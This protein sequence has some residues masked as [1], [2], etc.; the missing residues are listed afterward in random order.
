MSTTKKNI[1]LVVGLAFGLVIV[2]PIMIG[3]LGEWIPVPGNLDAWIG[4][5]GSLIGSALGII[6]SIYLLQKQM[7][8][9]LEQ[10]ENQRNIDSFYKLLDL[11]LREQDRI[12]QTDN[13]NNDQSTKTIFSNLVSDINSSYSSSYAVKYILLLKNNQDEKLTELCDKVDAIYNERNSYF[14]VIDKLYDDVDFYRFINGV[15][16][17]EKISD[18]HDILGN[19]FRVFHRTLKFINHN[20]NGEEKD[21]YIGD[22]RGV[23]SEFELLSLYYNAFYTRRGLGMKKEFENQTNFFG[24]KTDFI[25]VENGADHIFFNIGVITNS[26]FV[27]EDMKKCLTN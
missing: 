2:L 27:I 24:N 4:Y 14:D 1:I 22:L 23:L 9:N 7:K 17:E 3:C 18:K 15:I 16:V 11:F 26:K 25:E 5:W 6:G 12:R 20:F 21:E 10:I 19:Y 8:D 13:N